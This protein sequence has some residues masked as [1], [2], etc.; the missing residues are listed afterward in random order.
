MKD[1]SGRRMGFRLCIVL[2]L[3]FCSCGGQPDEEQHGRYANDRASDTT[4]GAR[5]APAAIPF[6][7]N[8]FISHHPASSNV[9]A[10]T[11]FTKEVDEF[12]K[13][14][15]DDPGN[16]SWTTLGEMR[17]YHRATERVYTLI[18][19]AYARTYHKLGTGSDRALF[20]EAHERWRTYFYAETAFLHEVFWT[21]ENLYGLGREHAIVQAQWAFQTAR[22]R[23]VLLRNIGEQLGADNGSGREGKDQ[24]P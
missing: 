20:R 9:Y 5:H 11:L 24:A 1:C 2:P 4:M 12:L 14:L 22:Q 16:E 17:C 3:A 8:Y 6:L 10:D 7:G 19:Q 23:L 13:D 18:E 21:N 15:L